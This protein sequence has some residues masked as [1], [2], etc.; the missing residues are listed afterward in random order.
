M[1]DSDE[2]LV[3][4][5][6]YIEE[7]GSLAIDV[8]EE[9]D[10]IITEDPTDPEVEDSWAVVLLKD[11]YKDWVVRFPRVIMDKGELEFDYEV[12]YLPEGSEFTDVTTASY[13]TAIITDIVANLHGNKEGQVYVDLDTGEQVE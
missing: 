6:V 3:L 11:P 8:L 1:N 9:D 13:M 12:I 5:P 4:D 10:Y 2:G 7:Q